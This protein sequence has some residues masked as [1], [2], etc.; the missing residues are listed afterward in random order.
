M[1]QSAAQITRKCHV[2]LIALCHYKTC[3]NSHSETQAMWDGGE[4]RPVDVWVWIDKWL[5]EWLLARE[6]QENEGAANN[7]CFNYPQHRPSHGPHYPSAGNPHRSS[8]AHHSILFAWKRCTFSWAPALAGAHE[9]LHLWPAETAPVYILKPEILFPVNWTTVGTMQHAGKT[10]RG[11]AGGE[12]INMYDGSLS[13]WAQTERAKVFVWKYDYE[14][15]M[16]LG[17]IVQKMVLTLMM[18]S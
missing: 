15:K 1:D 7:L 18:S 9:N 5:L 2:L 12:K 16:Q 4:N 14:P 3:V 6:H 10:V 13:C 11:R 8:W 17:Q